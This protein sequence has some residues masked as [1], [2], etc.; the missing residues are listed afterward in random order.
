[1][2]HE[3]NTGMCGFYR[4]LWIYILI[5]SAANHN[6]KA[7]SHPDLLIKLPAVY[8][9]YNPLHPFLAQGLNLIFVIYWLAQQLSNFL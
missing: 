5:F 3:C 9:T 6:D 8:C 4:S 7:V 2:Q 1:M